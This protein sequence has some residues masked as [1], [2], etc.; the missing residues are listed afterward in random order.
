[1]ADARTYEGKHL[2]QTV[3]LLSGHYGQHR[4]IGARVQE[5]GWSGI[6]NEVHADLL[7]PP[8]AG[9]EELAL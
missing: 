9:Q 2:D 7:P 3:M 8:P 5:E 1:M 4:T 6:W